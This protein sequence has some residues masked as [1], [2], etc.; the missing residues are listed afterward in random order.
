MYPTVSSTISLMI[1]KHSY[2]ILIFT[3]CDFYSNVKEVEGELYIWQ[4]TFALRIHV[5]V[6]STPSNTKVFRL[7]KFGNPVYL[8]SSCLHSEEKKIFLRE[9]TLHQQFSTTGRQMVIGKGVRVTSIIKYGKSRV[10]VLGSR[11][12]LCLW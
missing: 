4:L 1:K 3:V 12:Q 7:K 11:C 10:G 5:R 2:N 6:D 9:T 8:S